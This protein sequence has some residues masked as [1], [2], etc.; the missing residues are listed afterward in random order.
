MRLRGAL[1]SGRSTQKSDG[2]KEVKGEENFKRVSHA[3]SKKGQ[4]RYRLKMNH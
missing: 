2:T 4:V 1:K 3:N